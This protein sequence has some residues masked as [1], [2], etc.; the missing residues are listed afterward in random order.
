MV[1]LKCRNRHC[2][3]H[4]MKQPSPTLEKN[5]NIKKSLHPLGAEFR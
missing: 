1:S 5:R 3:G 2:A 4:S